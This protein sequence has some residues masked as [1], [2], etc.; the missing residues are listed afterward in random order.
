MPPS[1]MGDRSP[2]KVNKPQKAPS[3]ISGICLMFG[4]NVSEMVEEVQMTAAAVN[5][6][7]PLSLEPGHANEEGERRGMAAP[8]WGCVE[9]ARSATRCPAARTACAS[10]SRAR[11]SPSRRPSARAAAHTSAARTSASR[12]STA[13]AADSCCRVVLNSSSEL[14]YRF[15]LEGEAVPPPH[16]AD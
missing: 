8:K 4:C 3:L 1:T 6:P 12:A 11:C 10:S 15:T 7:A 16:A 2:T 14:G 13:R 9:I 5:K